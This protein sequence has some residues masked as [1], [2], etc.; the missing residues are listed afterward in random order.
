MALLKGGSLVS[1]SLIYV[2]SNLLVAALPL[3]FLPIL[4]RYLT[5]SDYNTVALFQSISLFLGSVFG[6]SVNGYCNINYFSDDRDVGDF[7]VYVSNGFFLLVAMGLLLTLVTGL[8]II[9]D[10]RFFGLDGIYLFLFPLAFFCQYAIYLRLGVYQVKKRPLN[11][12]HAILNV[13]FTVFIVIYLT[14]G[15]PG[16]ILAIVA[17]MVIAMLIS[18]TTLKREGLLKWQINKIVIWDFVK[19]GCSYAPIVIVATSIPLIERVLVSYILGPNKGGMFVVGT[20]IASGFLIII[21]SVMTAYSPYVYRRLSQVNMRKSLLKHLT[22]EITCF[23]IFAILTLVVVNSSF[24][25][26]VLEVMLPITYHE[27]IPLS[28][29]LVISVFFKVGFMVS[30]VYFTYEK[31][32]K[33]LTLIGFVFGSLNLIFFYIYLEDYGLVAAGI[34]SIIFKLGSSIALILLLV[35]YLK[36]RALINDYTNERENA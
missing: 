11:V 20:Q 7:S 30:S 34:G 33:L 19:Y 21:N 13:L 28:K 31:K 29:L 8:T 36:R 4:T 24:F 16:R 23:V 14:F 12:T 2:I 18:V 35:S 22:L 26:Y 1:H 27:S 15:G 17:A 3:L 6:L 9:L 5:P 10:L 25:R 32:N